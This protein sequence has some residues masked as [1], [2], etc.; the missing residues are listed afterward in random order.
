MAVE[1]KT[2]V[3]VGDAI[4]VTGH[5]PHQGAVFLGQLARRGLLTRL[6]RGLYALVP[7]G[8]DREFGNPFLVASSLAGSDPHFVSHLG[9]LSFHNLLLQPSR[10]LHVSIVRAKPA[11]EIG[12]MRIEFVVVPEKR[13]WGFR[14]EWVTNTDRAP[15]SDI[16][17]TIVDTCWRPELCGGIVEVGGALWL[18]R[19][20]LDP[21]RLLQYVRRFGKFVVA[22]RVGFLLETLEIDAAKIAEPLHD[23]AS[24][25]RPYSNLDTILPP[26]GEL[27]ARWRLRLNVTAEEL[28]AAT[29]A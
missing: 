8:K 20:R 25:S 16:E 11:R 3:H 13:L 28:I 4:R 19:D 14:Q 6:S 26:E 29:R 9:A 23:Y 22:R 18:G 27:N 12:P 17:R 7:F 10:T 2:L 1:G 21:Q 24:R 5:K 15:I